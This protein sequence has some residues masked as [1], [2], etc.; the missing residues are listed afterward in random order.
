MAV[1]G[2]KQIDGEWWYVAELCGVP[3]LRNIFLTGAIIDC[4]N[5]GLAVAEVCSV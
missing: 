4:L 1:I 5:L 3:I 2:R